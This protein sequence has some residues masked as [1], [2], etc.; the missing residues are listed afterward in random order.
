M[1]NIRV[2]IG[3]DVHAFSKNRK[4][5][6]GGVEIDSPFGLLGHSDADVLVHAII[7]SLLGSASLGDIGTHFPD[8]DKQYKDIR[9][10][11]LLNNIYDILC[12]HKIDIINIDCVVVCE[13]PKIA[14]FVDDMKGNIS[15]A[16]GGLS[17]S[18]IGIKGKTTEKLGF[19]GRAEGIAVYAVSLVNINE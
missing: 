4:L 6:L 7:D 8:S 11:I 15:G 16:L 9:S 1:N 14:A 2:G 19:T 5:I 3:F 13:K 17:K 10:I 18:R 12:K